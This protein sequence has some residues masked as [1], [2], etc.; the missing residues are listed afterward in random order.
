MHTKRMCDL[1]IKIGIVQD[2]LNLY[3]NFK[4]SCT[5]VTIH[6]P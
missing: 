1:S 2:L 3:G 4:R 6:T 5:I